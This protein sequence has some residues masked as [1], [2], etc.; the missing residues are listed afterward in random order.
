MATKPREPLIPAEVT[1]A[2]RRLDS[3]LKAHYR[4]MDLK[5]WK[6]IR[7][8]LLAVGILGFAA[9]AIGEGAPPGATAL[10]AIVIV[11][12]LAGMDALELLA[13]YAEVKQSAGGSS[14]ES[15]STTD[16]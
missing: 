2:N 14:T 11:A 16:Q 12:S 8:S 1:S 13:M 6:F 15:D 10:L 4:H 3:L 7:N 9:W 5:R